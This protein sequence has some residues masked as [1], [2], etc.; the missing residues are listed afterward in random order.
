M[1]KTV[2]VLIALAG[3]AAAFY[4]A[5]SNLMSPGPQSAVFAIIALVC[6]VWSFRRGGGWRFLAI[7]MIGPAV[8]V[9]TDALMRLLFWLNHRG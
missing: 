4:A 6:G 9:L 2:P 5:I 3:L 8:F 7:A 1:N